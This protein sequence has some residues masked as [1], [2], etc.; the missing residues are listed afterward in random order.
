LETLALTFTWNKNPTC[1][2]RAEMTPIY[3]AVVAGL[4]ACLCGG[5]IAAQTAPAS[6]A[7]QPAAPA[8]NV[9]HGKATFHRV[10]CYECHGLEAQGG[11]GTAPRLGPNPLPYARFSSYV[12]KP[13]GSMPP[14][15]TPVLS[16]QEMADIHAFL[17]AQP[18]PPA[19][20]S[21]PLLAPS[22]FK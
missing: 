5:P 11:P 16:E 10:G 19:L 3:V 1:V 7:A 17:R 14:Y 15:R 6:T 12:R 20:S 13:T 18:R 21:L 22:Q 4:L 2:R 9:E 8:G